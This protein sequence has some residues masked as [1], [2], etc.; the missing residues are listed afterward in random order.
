[1]DLQQTEAKA[2]KYS[3]KR[4][5]EACARLTMAV[6]PQRGWSWRSCADRPERIHPATATTAKSA[7]GIDLNA[8]SCGSHAGRGTATIARLRAGVA[9]VA[10]EGANLKADCSRAP[11]VR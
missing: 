11:P 4:I 2:S 5:T 9:G 7:R 1:M 3:V 6:S 8:D 10:A